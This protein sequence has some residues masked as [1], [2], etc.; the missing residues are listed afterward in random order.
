M[1]D[2][3]VT[4]TLQLPNDCPEIAVADMLPEKMVVDSLPARGLVNLMS[5]LGRGP[6]EAAP[7]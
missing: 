1:K 6:D 7:A 4:L 2:Y 5:S 3:T